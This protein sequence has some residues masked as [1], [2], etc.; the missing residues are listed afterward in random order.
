M[1]EYVAPLR[2]IQFVLKEL[3]GLDQVAQLPGYEDAT[4]DLVDAVL[5]EAAKFAEGVLSPLNIPGDREGAKWS[6][7]GSANGDGPGV[8]MPAGFKEAYALFAESGWTALQ[9]DPEWGGQG[10]PK[11]VG[12]A[13][14]EMWKSANH[15][16]SLCPLLTGGAAEALSLCGSDTL[17][18]TFLEKMTSGVWTGTMNLTEPQA[19]SDL[20]AIRSRAEPQADG[21]FRIFGQ[22]IFITYGDHDM[23]EN[24]VHLVLARTPTAPEGVKGI[25]MFVVPKF[26]VNADGS[27]GARNDAWCVSIEH[28]LGI[29]A[30]PTAVMAFGDHGGAVGYLVGEEN[31]GLEYMF[32]M[33]NAARF[34]VGLEG[35][36]ACE[37]AYQRA[38]DYARDRI[39][40][41]ETGVRGGPRVPIIRHPD[42]RRMLMSMR[43]HA[44]ATRALAYVVGAAHDVATRHPDTATRRR[45][46]A[47][48][49]LMIPVVKGWSTEVGIQVA[50]TGIQVHGGMGFIE[51]TG[52]AQYLRDAR[53]SAI[54]EGTTGIQANDLI[55][56]KMAR[57]GGA[58]L[59]ALIEEM[60]ALDA[61]LGQASGEH[62]AAIHRRFAAGVE[63]LAEA[64]RWIVDTYGVDVRA[65]S[66]GATPFLML[67]GIVAG[68]WQ[69]ARAALIAQAKIDAGDTDPFYQDKIVTARF[70][71]DHILS[72]ADGLADCITFGAPGVMALDEDRF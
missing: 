45:N 30:S 34:G 4:V 23:A 20:S 64:G 19:G 72:Q 6:A 67:L 50:S 11:L 14:T 29:H 1:S 25:S 16:F 47:F 13:V 37:R 12:A 58:T 55:G 42:V 44:E 43:A 49:D 46:Q 8:T 52:A 22:K 63:A 53:I 68:G 7:N 51:E 10:L 18:K 32:I 39:Q 27:L 54:Y 60:R 71:A 61:D 36:A 9:S 2:D 35:V 70:F 28:K 41:V 3:A 57:E 65:A 26:L 62:F 15:A 59:N 33:M 48:V 66:A 24:I 5:D 69:M 21:S 31:R 56:R 38:R 17:K 40:C